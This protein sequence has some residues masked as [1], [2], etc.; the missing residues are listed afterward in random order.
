M[1][2]TVRPTWDEG[3]KPTHH[4]QIATL[5]S[6]QVRHQ[7]T[8]RPTFRQVF[9]GSPAETLP[10]GVI[11][12]A[13]EPIY[14]K[15]W[16]NLGFQRRG[17]WDKATRSFYMDSVMRGIPLQPFTLVSLVLQFQAKDANGA[18]LIQ[19][20][21]RGELDQKIKDLFEL[22]SFDCNNR[23]ETGAAYVA[24]EF[25]WYPT[26]PEHKKLYP[27]GALY[28]ELTIDH[29]NYLNNFT[30]SVD[31][32]A[33]YTNPE[34]YMTFGRWHSTGTTNDAEDRN[35]S[36]TQ[37]CI[38]T[39]DDAA[40]EYNTWKAYK[41][42]HNAPAPVRY[43]KVSSKD[44]DIYPNCYRYSNDELIACA[45]SM[46][47]DYQQYEKYHEAR[48]SGEITGGKVQTP[49]TINNK[50]RL[51]DMYIRSADVV[52]YYPRFSNTVWAQFV[53]IWNANVKTD[54]EPIG[55][56]DQ[57]DRSDILSL[58]VAFDKQ[59][60]ELNDAS[61]FWSMYEK[62]QD[63]MDKKYTFSE[64]RV[65]QWDKAADAAEKKAK[66]LKNPKIY[67]WAHSKKSAWRIK[68]MNKR[69]EYML[70]YLQADD[71]KRETQWL[72][73][74]AIKCRRTAASSMQDHMELFDA[75]VN[76]PNVELEDV[77]E[78]RCE[79]DH[80]IPLARGGRDDQSNFWLVLA[81]DNNSRQTTD[82]FE[83]WEKVYP[84]EGKALLL[85]HLYENRLF[86]LTDR[87]LSFAGK[88]CSKCKP[89]EM[90][91]WSE[92]ALDNTKSHLDGVKS[93]CNECRNPRERKLKEERLKL[94][95][96]NNSKEEMEA[97]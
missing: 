59:G 45:F 89:G 43:F 34:I 95:E 63:R 47:A 93:D 35:A 16:L 38:L 64:T 12:P 68:G 4:A 14:K 80:Y 5:S 70:D 58:L 94:V 60:F 67:S 32:F 87:E 72:A 44:K 91:P 86:F 88:E 75:G 54:G 40:E 37:I 55:D 17:F 27:D 77:E 23:V 21:D 53:K 74:Q 30:F 81:K 19:G 3:I 52:H 24:D 66:K 82:W 84:K 41:A 96:M 7:T 83:Y 10:S 20:E 42:E 71:A 1:S 73:S 48:V 11:V 8:Y 26:D 56:M 29:R 65:R 46:Y 49:S 62:M 6:G 50:H 90:I 61:A 92:Y 13:V 85:E 31:V 22:M 39:R 78:G 79:V 18:Y 97:Q 69:L 57:S 51:K 25:K 33:G 9:I 76:A 2:N 36:N 28:S 15:I